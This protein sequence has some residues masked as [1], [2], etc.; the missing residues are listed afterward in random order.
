MFWDETHETLP[1][2]DLERLQLQRLQETVRR[3][4]ARV[5][6]YQRKFNDLG[7]TPEAIRSLADLR[8]LPFTTN[9]DLRANY[10][11]GLLAVPYDQTLRLHTSS[12]TTGKPKALFFS[13]QDVNNAAELCARAFIATGVR[14]GDVFQ[15]MM[16]YGM[17][18][19]ALVTHYGA[20]KVGCLVIPAGPGNSERQVMLMR[21]FGSTVIHLTPSY[22][23]YLATFLEKHGVE[24]RRDLQLRK[25]FVGAEPYTEETRRKIEEGLGLDVYNSYGLSEMNGPGV[26]FECEQKQGMHLWEDHFL[27]EILDPETDEPVPEGQSGELVL[28]TLCRE[29]M[30]LLRYRTRDVT[31]LI[32]AP[33]ACGRTHR[34]LHRITG[35]AD[36]ML[37][38]RGVNIYPQQIER[39]LMAQPGIGRNYL[40]ELTG[41]DEMTVKVELA[42][43]GFGGQVEQLIA[44]QKKLAEKLRAEIL[45]KPTVQLVP[46][47]DLPV[48]EGKAKRVVDRRQL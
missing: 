24:P 16:T 46:P 40:I 47:G 33:C 38:L 19:G 25:A 48:S 7:L 4:F 42:E 28:T 13:R 45:C 9:A 2:P 22:A 35:R 41:L 1:R 36:D 10:P 23:L 8:R 3:V 20:E 30:P 6:F 43:A 18:T 31:A 5:P 15:N 11:A 37:I 14:A 26:A 12:G 34:R 32:T 39:V 17:F 44:L 29:A 21:D 27:V